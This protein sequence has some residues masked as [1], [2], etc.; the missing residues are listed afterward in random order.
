MKA[1]DDAFVHVTNLLEKSI[2]IS[3]ISTPVSLGSCSSYCD[4]GAGYLL[5]AFALYNTFNHSLISA[6]NRLVASA[7]PNSNSNSNKQNKDNDNN[8]SNNKSGSDNG[9][10]GILYSPD[11]RVFTTSED[12]S[13]FKCQRSIGTQ[14]KNVPGFSS[15]S[16][17]G[18]YDMD[19]TN[20]RNFI[21]YHHLSPEMLYS[22]SQQTLSSDCERVSERLLTEHGLKVCFFVFFHLPRLFLFTSHLF[23]NVFLVGV[24]A[25]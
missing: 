19:K 11:C 15:R 5:N 24:C 3:D 17:H 1:D 20:L 25:L 4:G 22:L 8:N 16:P 23:F 10:N 14:V 9:S 7:Q 21:T 18:I 13:M 2:C 6:H 12:I